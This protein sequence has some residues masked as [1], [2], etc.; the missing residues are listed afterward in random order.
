MVAKCRW[1]ARWDGSG[2]RF[3]EVRLDMSVFAENFPCPLWSKPLSDSSLPLVSSS[4]LCPPGVTLV[5]RVS[6]RDDPKAER[7]VQS[8]L[9]SDSMPR[10]AFLELLLGPALLP[11]EVLAEV[12]AAVVVGVVVVLVVV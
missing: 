6:L 5:L 11:L 10:L 1:V 12:P 8:W 2:D 7:L 3:G 9:V 4:W